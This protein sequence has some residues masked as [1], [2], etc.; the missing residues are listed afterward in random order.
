MKTGIRFITLC[1]ALL[2]CIGVFGCK[3]QGKTI[4]GYAL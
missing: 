1:L 4:A 3:P 2:L